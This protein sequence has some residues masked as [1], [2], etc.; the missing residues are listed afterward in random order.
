MR[1]HSLES[2]ALEMASMGER[3]VSCDGERCPVDPLSIASIDKGRS[4]IELSSMTSRNPISAS[5]VKHDTVML[6]ERH[7]P[8]IR[9]A[10]QACVGCFRCFTGTPPR[11]SQPQHCGGTK[12]SLQPI[13]WLTRI[14]AFLMCFSHALRC[15]DSRFYGMYSITALD[16]LGTSQPS[17]YSR[18]YLVHTSAPFSSAEGCTYLQETNVVHKSFKKDV[19]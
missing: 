11:K 13:H 6:S 8:K 14:G 17:S 1:R 12:A 2:T 7:Q 5:S 18:G 3:S 4:T 19:S 9:I 15:L 10:D 16:I